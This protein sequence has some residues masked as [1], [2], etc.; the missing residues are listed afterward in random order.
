MFK[1]YEKIF[2]EMFSNE[3]KLITQKKNIYDF[4]MGFKTLLLEHF[5]KIEDEVIFILF[6][7][8]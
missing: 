5:S 2:K 4:L 6:Y 3:K 1:N 7:L 8:Y